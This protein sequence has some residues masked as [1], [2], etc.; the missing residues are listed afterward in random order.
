MP[1]N[2]I[3]P[4]CS[5]PVSEKC[6]S[7][8]C[9]NCDLWV[10]QSKC[11]GLS[12]NQFETFS[13]PNSDKWCCL[14]CTDF[15]L[16]FHNQRYE[17]T[18]DICATSSSNVNEKLKSLLKE[19]NN[20]VSGISNDNEDIL[21]TQFHSNRCSY[22]DCNEFNSLYLKTPTNFSSFHL[23]IAS[24]SKHFDEL[25]CML[26]QLNCNF[27]V[28]GISETRNVTTVSDSVSEPTLNQ[29]SIPGY[30]L[31]ST[32]TASAAGGVSL[33][34]LNSFCTKPRYDLSQSLYLDSNLE[35][36]FAEIDL[37]N[38]TN[39]IVGNIYRHPCM[40]IKTFNTEFLTP[41]LHKMATEKKQILLQLRKIGKF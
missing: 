31:F 10:H 22:L 7:I 2:Y 14:S 18:E 17:Q 29:F 25:T 16:P 26:A 33:Y 20:V 39:I 37:P 36:T 30:K 1:L 41:L 19:L 11:S 21:E 27:S 23:N 28:I 13:K 24:L 38:Q 12:L 32:P 40:S 15:A 8:Q 3:C 35:S 34:I 4:V 9:D 6:R 5:K